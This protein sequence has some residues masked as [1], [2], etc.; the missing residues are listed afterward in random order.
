VYDLNAS[1]YGIFLGKLQNTSILFSAEIDGFWGDNESDD[2]RST[3]A[4]KRFD[5]LDTRIAELK[6]IHV[7]LYSKALNGVYKYVNIFALYF[8][9]RSIFNQLRII[10]DQRC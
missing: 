1:S 7:D 5:D 9:F 8:M 2:W 10:L 6:T 4:K 3:A